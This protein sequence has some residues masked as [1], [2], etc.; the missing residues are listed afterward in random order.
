MA[1]RARGRAGIADRDPAGGRGHRH[2]LPREGGGPVAA[3]V[4]AIPKLRSR[5]DGAAVPLDDADRRLLNLLQSKLPL[6]PHPFAAVAE[7]AELGEDE[8]LER[9]ERLI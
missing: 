6:A 2:H 9:T 7:A 1:G 5:A 8:V 3:N 4:G